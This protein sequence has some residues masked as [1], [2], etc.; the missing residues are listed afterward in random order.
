ML[1][2]SHMVLSGLPL[3]QRNSGVKDLHAS[4]GLISGGAW[5]G[6]VSQTTEITGRERGRC[7]CCREQSDEMSVYGQGQAGSTRYSR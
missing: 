4:A 5:R 7:I 6:S 3:K 1:L 2:C